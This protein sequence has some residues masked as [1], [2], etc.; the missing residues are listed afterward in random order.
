MIRLSRKEI[1]AG[2]YK[3]R[4]GLIPLLYSKHAN[5]RLE[6]RVN[7]ELVVFPT[8]VRI[9][10]DNLYNGSVRNEKILIE[11]CVRI[12]YK[13]DKWMFIALNIRSGVVKSI[14]IDEKRTKSKTTKLRGEMGII[15]KNMEKE[16]SQIP[17]IWHIFGESVE[18]YLLRSSI[19]E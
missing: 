18:K 8:V 16:T 12:D 10:M 15:S 14:W 13:R 11:A 4:E 3:W 19:R 5:K 6:E 2:E 7:G 9:T 17:D 1:V